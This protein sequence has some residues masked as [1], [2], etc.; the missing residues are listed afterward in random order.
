MYELKDM[1]YLHDVERAYRRPL[2]QR[3]VGAIK[4]GETERIWGAKTFSRRQKN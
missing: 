2:L 1:A 3:I 4:P